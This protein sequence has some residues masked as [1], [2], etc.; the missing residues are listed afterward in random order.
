MGAA[1]DSDR[2]ELDFRRINVELL[3]NADAVVRRD[4]RFVKQ[5]AP[6]LGGIYEYSRTITIVNRN[7]LDE[8][9]I[10]IFQEQEEELKELE[11]LIYD[12]RGR[13]VR[14]MGKADFEQA[15]GLADEPVAAFTAQLR[16]GSFPF[17]FH[18]RYVKGVE[19]MGEF[20]VWRPAGEGVALEEGHY[21]LQIPTGQRLIAERYPRED[22]F[23]A[24]ETPAANAQEFSWRISNYTSRRLERNGPPAQEVFPTLRLR[25]VL[26]RKHGYHGR[27]QRWNDVGNWLRSVRFARHHL[28]P[29]DML[30]AR[31]LRPVSPELQSLLDMRVYPGRLAEVHPL[32]ASPPEPPLPDAHLEAVFHHLGDSEFYELPQ[33]LWM[34]QLAY[35]P[36]N[37]PQPPVEEEAPEYLPPDE[38]Q[39]LNSLV[40]YVIRRV[41]KRYVSRPMSQ[42]DFVPGMPRELVRR[43]QA[44]ADDI[45]YY[46]R[47]LLKFAGIEAYQAFLISDSYAP[48]AWKE[49]PQPGL[50][51][52]HAVTLAVVEG[53]TLWIDPENLESGFPLTY[54]GYA[55]ANRRALL[56]RSD[57]AVLIQTPPL[58]ADRN[59]QRRRA[60][61]QL[62]ENGHARARIFTE[63][64]GQQHEFIRRLAR[65]SQQQ[66]QYAL[67]QSLAITEYAI[68][69]VMVEADERQPVARMELLLDISRLANTPGRQLLF[70][71]NLL[72]QRTLNIAL[73][74]PRRQPV[75]IAYG[76]EDE[77]IIT[78]TLPPGYRVEEL[79]E[80]ADLRFPLGFYKVDISLAED[81]RSIQYRRQLRIERGRIPAESYRSYVSFMNG[82]YREDRR[83]VILRAD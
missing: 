46:L 82:L 39:V 7:G 65:R 53:D 60:E 61:V 1:A 66:Q 17:T 28:A 81:G 52:D 79:P 76:Y 3:E 24:E 64:T 13:F 14:R 30:L 73:S 12:R 63:Y 55:L 48:P 47:T 59:R 58:D 69:E 27:V 20:P 74:E 11:V 18:L 50:R 26:I 43:Q 32:P 78:Y 15:A 70:R 29:E 49:R 38:F 35:Q 54:S 77:D 25:P 80:S 68:H 8:A 34:P 75:V 4:Y 44:D 51:F 2:P 33:L 72:E 71:P 6:G 19:G 9:D 42:Y 22:A 16:H 37:Q 40:D 56:L 5:Q 45:S 21:R 67:F 36:K 57:D 62:K 31:R 83:E 41:G 23:E 10:R